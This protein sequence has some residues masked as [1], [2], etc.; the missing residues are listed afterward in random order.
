LTRSNTGK[1][2]QAFPLE[3]IAST[4]FATFLLSLVAWT[5]SGYQKR[6]R[7]LKTNHSANV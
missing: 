2:A 5:Y 6:H 1:R 7:A 4:R 3:S